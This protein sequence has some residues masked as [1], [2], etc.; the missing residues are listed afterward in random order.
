MRIKCL[1]VDGGERF[2]KCA[3]DIDAPDVCECVAVVR[4][5]QRDWTFRRLSVFLLAIGTLKVA[6]RSRTVNLFGAQIQGGLI[7]V[8]QSGSV[9]DLSA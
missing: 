2:Y 7:G 1:I 8:N 4:D 5:G 6:L 3:L 9:A